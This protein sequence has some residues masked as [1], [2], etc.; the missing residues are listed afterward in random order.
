MKKILMSGGAGFVGSHLTD[1]FLAKG[2]QVTVVDNLHSGQVENLAH[3][4]GNPNFTFQNRD[5]CQDLS[6]LYA[7]EWDAVLNLASLASP[8]DYTKYPIETLHVG[9]L[10]TENML[11][12][13]KESGAVFLMTSTSEVYGDP[14]VHPQQ[15]DYWGNVNPY[16][17]R[18]CYDESKRY[19]EALCFTYAQ[20]FDVKVRIARIFNTYGPR[21]RVNDGRVVPTFI[22]Q[23]LQGESLTIFGDGQ[24]TRSFCFVSDLVEGLERLLWSNYDQPV[25]LGNPQ[26]MTI[27]EFAELIVE[28]TGSSSEIIYQPLPH[29][30]DPKKRCPNIQRAKEILKWE[31]T[32]P[33]RVGFQK[34]IDYYATLMKQNQS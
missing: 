12:V 10:G 31:P 4:E 14:E 28:L 1:H 26:E 30:D 19:S 20:Q 11:K 9:S 6:D 7:G 15:E 5:I 23:A 25:N 3:L 17:S 21:N 8:V 22:N 33:P 29:K 13:A 18:S 16:G 34:T 24:Q 27:R 2:N 32:V